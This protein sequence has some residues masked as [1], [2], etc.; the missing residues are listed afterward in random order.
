MILLYNTFCSYKFNN[1]LSP[2]TFSLSN[3][4]APLNLPLFLSIMKFRGS[5]SLNE[6]ISFGSNKPIIFNNVD[7]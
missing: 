4:K 2:I 3:A 5:N 7:R 6:C 1:R